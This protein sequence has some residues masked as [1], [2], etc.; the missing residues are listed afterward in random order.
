ME[1][2]ERSEIKAFD[3]DHGTKDI[4]VRRYIWLA[5]YGYVLILQRKRHYKEPS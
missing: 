5:E 2:P 3:Y 1:S 4:G